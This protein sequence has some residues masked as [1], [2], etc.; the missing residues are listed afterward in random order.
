[1]LVSAIVAKIEMGIGQ[2]LYFS[3]KP[4]LHQKQL[5]EQ[6]IQDRQSEYRQLLTATDSLVKRGDLNTKDFGRI[7]HPDIRTIMAKSRDQFVNC[8]DTL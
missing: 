2:T 6:F 7:S 5:S 4:T 8:T 1:M 3:E